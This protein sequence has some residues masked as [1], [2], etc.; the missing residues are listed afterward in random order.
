MIRTEKTP[1]DVSNFRYGIQVRWSDT[2]SYKH[3]NYLSYVRFCFDAAQEAVSTGWLSSFSGDILLYD[4]K[5][6][7][8]LY[9]AETRV[10]D[11]LTMVLWPSK[12]NSFELHF[13]LE[14]ADN[15]VAFQSVIEFYPPENP[16]PAEVTH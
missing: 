4:V 14:K 7:Q 1:T 16:K 15:T 11:Q 8:M 6:I 12:T 10:N 2:D 13:S 9:K 3:T 5:T